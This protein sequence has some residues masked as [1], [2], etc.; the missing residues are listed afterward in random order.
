MCFWRSLFNISNIIHTSYACPTCISYSRFLL[1]FLLAFP[2]AFPTCI[3]YMHFPMHFLHAFPTCISYCI[4]CPCYWLC[5]YSWITRFVS[6]AQMPSSASSVGS[7]KIERGRVREL[8]GMQPFTVA[9]ERR[10]LHAATARIACSRCVR[11]CILHMHVCMYVGKYVF[12]YVCL[13]VCLSVCMY[14][15]MYLCMYAAC[16]YVCMYMHVKMYVC[17]YVCRHV[18]MLVCKQIVR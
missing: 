6:L 3:S 1:H 7:P 11:A 15:C 2:I 13:S 12:M 4:P 10:D 14:A 8:I 9:G 18:G 5:F 17:M 16:M